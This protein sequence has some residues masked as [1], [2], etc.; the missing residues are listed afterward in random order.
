MFM[1]LGLLYVFLVSFLVFMFRCVF[2][3][4]CCSLQFVLYGGSFVVLFFVCFHCLFSS[5][6]VAVIVAIA[7]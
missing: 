4:L 5:L 7:Y 6:G 1:F 3:C 2:V